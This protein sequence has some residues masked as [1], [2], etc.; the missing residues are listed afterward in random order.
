VVER[1]RSK[2]TPCCRAATRFDKL[3]VCDLAFVHLAAI[4]VF[5]RR[6]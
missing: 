5:L 3:D 2:V 4:P 6:P 1:F